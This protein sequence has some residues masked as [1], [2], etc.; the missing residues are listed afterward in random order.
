MR[1]LFSHA[2]LIYELSLRNLWRQR[3]RNT[4]LLLSVICAISGVVV[5]NSLVRGLQVQMVDQVVHNLNGH[6]IVHAPNY[7][8]DPT[9][10]RGFTA[11][12][13]EISRK[14]LPLDLKGW[15]TR[16]K[17]PAVVMSERETRG[18]QIVGLDPSQEH[19]SV[20]AD[21]SFEG[22]SLVSAN[23]RRVVIGR[24]L[25]TQLRTKVGHRI[26][27]VMQDANSNSIEVGFQIAGTFDGDSDA[28]EKYSIFVGKE[29]LQQF[30]NSTHVTELSIRF[31]SRLIPSGGLET[32]SQV[33]PH[34]VAIDWKNID[35]IIAFMYESVNAMVYIWLAIVLTALIF[36]L[37][38]TFITAV[39]ER[40]QEIGLCKSMGMKSSLVLSQVVT[41]S[42]II[43]LIGL[44][45]GLSLSWLILQLIGEGIDLQAFSAGFE[46]MNLAPKIKP[47]VVWQ[48]IRVVIIA[49]VF[50][51]LFASLY[52]AVRAVR[53]DPLVALRD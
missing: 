32:I 9:I 12:T 4:V 53:L 5:L 7:V 51:A 8:E 34:L 17:I 3:R 42:L 36:G 48:D 35:P 19:I 33:F 44:I 43:M 11:N 1:S 37:M 28:M 18:V 16:I 50:L 6:I 29:T 10:T 52:P 22:D 20:F 45:G 47:A 24:A 2:T 31:D 40:T 30:L 21:L 13:E 25:L 14:L 49:T 39:L 46:M 23:D 15:A 27:V 38:N 41:E 26:V